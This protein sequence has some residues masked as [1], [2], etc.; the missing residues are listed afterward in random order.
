MVNLCKNNE[1]RKEAVSACEHLKDVFAQNFLNTE[2]KLKY[3]S[4]SISERLK[5][6]KKD[7]SLSGAVPTELAQFYLQHKVKHLYA[8]YLKSLENLLSDNLFFIKKTCLLAMAQLAKF[9]D[10]QNTIL[11]ALVNKFG[12]SDMQV[13]NEL[14]KVLRLEVGLDFELLGPLL[15]NIEEMMFRKNISR[16]AQFYCV[17]LLTNL[18]LGL[19]HERHLNSLMELY[20]KLFKKLVVSEEI[21]PTEPVKQPKQ[22]KKGKKKPQ[23][24]LKLPQVDTEE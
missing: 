13:V 12:D 17:N 1:N 24:K 18:N 23:Q 9:P 19:I 15:R 2:Q 16:H 5:A 21:K 10:M 20:F 22:D 3:F 8:E 6:A 7:K 4:E 11:S 14:T